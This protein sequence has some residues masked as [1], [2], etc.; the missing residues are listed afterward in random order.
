MIKYFNENY[1]RVYLNEHN[2]EIII[3]VKHKI[4]LLYWA[5][6]PYCEVGVAPLKEAERKCACAFCRARCCPLILIRKGIKIF[7]DGF[8]PNTCYR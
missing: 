6:F 7:R 3:T 2:I 5:R 8:S 1:N 4:M